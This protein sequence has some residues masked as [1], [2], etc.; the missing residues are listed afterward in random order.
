M[1][2]LSLTEFDQC[3]HEPQ[4]D[5]CHDTVA[6]RSWLTLQAI[7]GLGNGTLYRLVRTFGS[8]TQV[9]EAPFHRLI[10]AGG[11]Y[12]SLAKS[13]QIGPDTKAQQDIERILHMTKEGNWSIISIL[14]PAYPRRLT[15]IPN[16]PPLLYVTGCLKKIDDQALA[17]V[18]S[19]RATLAGRA[20]TQNLSRDLAALGFTIVSG[21]ARGIDTAAHRGA[22][23]SSGRTLA[24]L[25]CG[26]DRTYP[27]EQVPLRKDI[28]ANGAVLSEFPP[29]TPPHAR[30]FPQ[31]NRIIS[32]LCL[33][34]VV[35]E[36]ALQSGS[37][38]TA[39]LAVEQNRDVFAVPGP[40][41]KEN[42]RGPHNLIKQGAK[43]I[44]N[45]QDILEELIPQLDGDLL[46]RINNTLSASSSDCLVALNKQEQTV[47]DLLSLIPLSVD[48]V[49]TQSRLYP[50][51]VIGILLSLEL[52]GIAQHMPGA[53]Y[54]RL[55][56]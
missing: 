54:I 17:I 21:M 25:G 1:N 28:E 49:I 48:E 34:V 53:Q 4:A 18:G 50:A 38:I 30:H 2:T 26:I 45:S 47:Y 31:R 56:T 35:T 15:M 32:G 37:L 8:P 42:H 3:H 27:P 13:I 39:K 41:T 22:L 5:I 14:D 6:L 9:L 55:P 33:G 10:E 23:Q 24:V 29:G 19:R 40:V 44:E 43:L 16:P 11:I 51:E 36:A 7:N 12:E 20:L 52:K 46:N